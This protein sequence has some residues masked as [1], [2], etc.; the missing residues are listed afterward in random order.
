MTE[1]VCEVCGRKIDSRGLSGHMRTH[2]GKAKVCVDCG[3]TE[4]EL[5]TKIR[6]RLQW[7]NKDH[8]YNRDNLEDWQWVH[9]Y[10]HT[11]YDM[12]RRGE[13]DN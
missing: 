11:H 9:Y 3:K 12:K 2:K 7:S 1:A 5:P 8:K 10:C 6:R 13:K 4:K